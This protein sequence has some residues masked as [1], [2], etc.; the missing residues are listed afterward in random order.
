LI[1]SGSFP[2]QVEKLVVLDGVTMLP[3]AQK[4]PAHER[5]G[6]WIGQLDR[7]HDRTP[8]RY[9][10]LGD[11]AGQMMLHNRRLSRDLALHLATH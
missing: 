7:L 1:F 3:D 4:P 10:T 6:K 11:A 9:A 2:E 8:R 5:I